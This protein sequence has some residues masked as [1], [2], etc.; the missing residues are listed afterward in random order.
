MSLSLI[1]N[2]L[3]VS[4]TVASSGQPGED[5]FR[6]IADAGFTVVINL[7]MPESDNA[8]AEEGDIVESL[9]MKYLH[10]PVPF[11]SP[12][13]NQLQTFFDFMQA[14]ENDKVWV[15]CVLNY[16]VSAFLYLYEKL[17]KGATEEQA[18]KV[19]LPDWHPD[20]VWS[21]F[22]RTTYQDLAKTE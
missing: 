5:Q 6:H 10:I 19:M 7:A 12:G 18:R 22:L 1:R 2:Y 20:S 21:S 4:Q 9:G 8:I 17:V 13:V 15:H 14:S 11:D 3:Q 16:R